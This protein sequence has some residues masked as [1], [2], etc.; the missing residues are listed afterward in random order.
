[1]INAI[2]FSVVSFFPTT[3]S[4]DSIRT[5]VVDGKIYII[6]RVESKETL[7]SISKKYGVA[8]LAVVESNP[9]SSS[10]VEVGSMIKVPYSANNRTKTANGTIHR[11]GQKETLYSIAKQYG[12]TVDDIKSWNKN[13]ANGLKIGQE[14]LIKNKIAEQANT[15]AT[16]TIAQPTNSST[17]N[18]HTVAAQETMYA[19]SR[20]YGITI[21]QIKD[22]NQLTSNDLKPGQKIFTS[23]PNSNAT[24]VVTKPDNGRP[25]NIKPQPYIVTQNSNP[26]TNPTITKPTNTVIT[27]ESVAGSDEVHEKGMA[28][29]LDG[30]EGNRKYLAHHRTL[31]SGTIVRVINN[32]T[33]KQVFVRII[34]NLDNTEAPDV[35]LRISKSAFDMLGGNERFPVEVSYF[36]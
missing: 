25:E 27:T 7:F 30:T 31:K 26:T 28:I 33:Q 4:I 16:S 36:K 35:L 13:A 9:S 8:L 1:M 14:L 6:H 2:I 11:V 20:K 17:Q 32:A 12:V 29:L 21:Q 23:A 24:T 15:A 3:T 34:G 5:E 10:G 19:I 22:W 18:T